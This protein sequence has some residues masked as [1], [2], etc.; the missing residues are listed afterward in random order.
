MLW[1]CIW[2]VVGSDLGRNT[3]Y[4]DRGFLWFSSFSQANSRLNISLGYDCFVVE[5]FQF[6]CYRA[7]RCYKVSV[8]KVLLN[9]KNGTMWDRMWSMENAVVLLNIA[10]MEYGKKVMFW[11][12]FVYDWIFWLLSARRSK[13]NISQRNINACKS[14]SKSIYFHNTC[15]WIMWSSVYWFS[16]RNKQFTVIMMHQIL[17][18][19]EY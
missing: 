14:T 11:L 9:H 17:N 12:V 5:P 16:S 8:L 18:G 13:I 6:M 10:V 19:K 1:P 4:P 2:E 3:K 15:L 7:I